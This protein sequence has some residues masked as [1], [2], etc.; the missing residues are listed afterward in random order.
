MPGMARLR[1]H[2]IGNF[3]VANKLLTGYPGNSEKFLNGTLA[4]GLR[5]HHLSIWLVSMVTVDKHYRI[6]H[7]HYSPD[8]DRNDSWTQSGLEES[9][10]NGEIKDSTS[11]GSGRPSLIFCYKNVK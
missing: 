6:K 5:V 11:G 4:G 8:N 1:A 3:W 10:V 9:K 2:S 7:T